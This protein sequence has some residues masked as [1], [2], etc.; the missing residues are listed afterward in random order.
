MHGAFDCFVDGN[1]F[2]TKLVP[3]KTVHKENSSQQSK[4]LE[5]RAPHHKMQSVCN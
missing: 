1:E 2:V 3:K 5:I 4:V